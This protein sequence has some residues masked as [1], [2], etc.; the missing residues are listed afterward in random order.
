MSAGNTVRNSPIGRKRQQRVCSSQGAIAGGSS[1]AARAAFL[2]DGD[3]YFRAFVAA[4]RQAQRSILIT[5]WDFHSRTRL[6]CG[7][8]TAANAN[9][10]WASFSTISRASAADSQIHILIW[11]YPMIFGMDREW[12]PIYGLGWKP[13][14]RVHFR[15]DNTHPTGGSHHQ[16]IVVIDDAVAFNG[17]LDLTCRRWDTCAH[18]AQNA[19]RVM[20]GTPY[21]PFHDLMMAVEGDAA[22]ALGD[23]VRERWRLATG[24]TAET[25]GVT[26]AAVAAAQT[27]DLY[28]M[29]RR[30]GRRNS[31]PM[32]AMSGW[33]S[34]APRR[35]VNGHS[36]VREVEELYVDMIAAARHASTSRTSIS[37]PTGSA[38][39]W[40]RGC[41]SRRARRSSWCCANSATAGSKRLTMEALR[42]KTDCA[43]EGGG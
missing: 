1:S 38:T 9:W 24:E 29:R 27:R 25:R 31:R 11:D 16:K 2:I 3:A 7:D 36:G 30:D 15:Y 43:A 18:A 37:Q 20:Q 34:R 5:G 4:A 32:S 26:Q 21:P 14:R 42:T 10:S 28:P 19:H 23:L 40:K 12:A 13:H 41:R 8:D 33:R 17:G 6:L 35:L 22:R 39:H